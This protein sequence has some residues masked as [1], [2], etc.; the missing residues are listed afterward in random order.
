M[1]TLDRG[2]RSIRK[3]LTARATGN[4]R[5]EPTAV[6]TAVQVDLQLWERITPPIFCKSIILKKV[7]VVCFDKLL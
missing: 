2:Q 4:C 7:K 1:C 6:E 3:Q 5:L